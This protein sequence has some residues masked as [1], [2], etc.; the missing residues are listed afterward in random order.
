[1]KNIIVTG[2]LAYDFIFDFD[3]YFSNYILPEKIH[4]INISLLTDYYKKSYGGT[5]GNQSYY[6]TKL[7]CNNYIY[8]V[9][10]NDFT[11]Y[12]KFLRKNGIVNKYIK[13]YK[14]LHTAAGFAITDKKDNQI[15]M[16]SRGVMKHTSNLS[17]KTLTKNMND[18]F[19]LITPNDPKAISKFVDECLAYKLDF[20]FDIGFNIPITSKNTL[21]KG[22]K[23]ATII[24]GNDY[25]ID[26][27]EKITKI[28]LIKN[29][30]K[31]QILIK[32]LADEGSEIYTKNKKYEIGIY[33]TKTIDPTGAGDAYRSGFIYGYLNNYPLKTCGWMGA[34]TASFAVE[35]KGT[36]N[37]KFTRDKFKERLRKL[38]VQSFNRLD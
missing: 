24:F 29:L 25:E 18:I 2:T 12:S 34:I 13:I 35:V 32:T 15:W 16:Y 30:K 26:L 5:A 27:I 6:L 10:G 23:N 14:N 3:N 37:L 8:G 33:K 11:E 19:I 20:T 7:G 21:I 38:K 1:M 9:G 4:Q 17:L 31:N 22:V 28:P 36:M